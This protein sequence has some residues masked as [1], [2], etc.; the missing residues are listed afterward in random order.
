MA[1]F[2]RLLYRKFHQCRG[3]IQNVS[4]YEMGV[5][6]FPIVVIF[7][8]GCVPEV[9]V[10]L[11]VAG[12]IYIYI[13][14]DKP[15]CVCYITVQ[16]YDVCKLSSTLWLVGHIPD[17]KVHGTNMGPIWDRQDPGGPHDGPMILAIWDS[18]VCTSLSHHHHYTDVSEGIGFL[19]YL[20]AIFC[21][22]CPRLN[23]FSQLSVMQYMGL[24]VFGLSISLMMIVRIRLLCLNIIMK[25]EVWPVCHC[26]GL[27]HKTL[28]CAICLSIFLYMF[29]RNNV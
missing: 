11:Y 9:V 21:R 3:I 6:M 27:G 13:S 12:F 8:R 4:A 22:V 19:K 26:L 1:F 24:C 14:P 29:L 10:P 20:S 25:S 17:S 18:F 5:S 2:C 15:G 23:Q 28:V 16:S 7:V